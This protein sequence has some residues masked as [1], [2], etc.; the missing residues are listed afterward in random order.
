M[1]ET[2]TRDI[3]GCTFAIQQLP[4]MRAAKLFHKLSSALAPAIGA[5]FGKGMD[6]EVDNLGEAA[7]LLF[8]RLPAS[9]FEAVIRELLETATIARE[10]MTMP[11]MPVFD[12]VMAG[13]MKDLMGVLV[14]ALEVN[15]GDFFGDIGAKARLLVASKSTSL[16]ASKAS[17]VAIG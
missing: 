15:Y 3:G 1:R 13:K 16:G 2:K 7:K 6:G 10:G 4:G 14:F 11:L 9:E 5:A 12:D 8:D 17:G